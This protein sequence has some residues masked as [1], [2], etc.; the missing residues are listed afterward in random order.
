[1]MNV[2][3]FHLILIFVVILKLGKTDEKKTLCRIVVCCYSAASNS[4]LKTVREEPETSQPCKC[5]SRKSV[6]KIILKIV[7]VQIIQN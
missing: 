7:L 1:M 3:N 6:R 2:V 5:K 4:N